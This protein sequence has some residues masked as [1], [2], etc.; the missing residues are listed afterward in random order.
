[1]LLFQ[2]AF[3]RFTKLNIHIH[4]L[5]TEAPTAHQEPFGV[6]YTSTCSWGEPG[7]EPVTFRLL[8]DLLNLLRYS[9]PKHDS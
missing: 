3:L 7:F 5:M 6:Q 9:R 1:M 2:S 8:D 4:T